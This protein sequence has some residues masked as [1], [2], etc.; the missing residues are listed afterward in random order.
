MGFPCIWL[1]VF[2]HPAYGLMQHHQLYSPRLVLSSHRN[3]FKFSCLFCHCHYSLNQWQPPRFLQEPLAQPQQFHGGHS[4]STA[5]KFLPGSHKR[6]ALR[7]ACGHCDSSLETLVPA[8]SRRCNK[9]I[10]IQEKNRI[11]VAF[12]NSVDTG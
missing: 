3:S 7:A 2:D 9:Q 10:K 11:K 12:I 4:Q 5:D 1:S 8:G 6:R